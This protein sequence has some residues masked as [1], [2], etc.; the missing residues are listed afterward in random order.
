[1]CVTESYLLNIILICLSVVLNTSGAF[2]L[3]LT[4]VISGNSAHPFCSL[5][6]LLIIS[7][8]SL[9]W[10][11]FSSLLN[12]ASLWIQFPTCFSH[13]PG[14]PINSVSRVFTL[15]CLLMTSKSVFLVTLNP[16]IEFQTHATN[17]LLGMS[18]SL[19]LKW[20][21]HSSSRNC[22]SLHE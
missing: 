12:S 6:T 22:Y 14:S 20:T 17:H 18:N 7:S 10:Q 11:L 2:H 4:T 16:F 8:Y 5:P 9:S 19:C 15:E 21:H 3:N 13:S 1:M